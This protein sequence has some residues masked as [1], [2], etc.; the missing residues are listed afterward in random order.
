VCSII[1][2]INKESRLKRADRPDRW[3]VV[4]TLQPV[5]VVVDPINT[6]SNRQKQWN[7]EPTDFSIGPAYIIYY[8]YT[9]HAS[10][11]FED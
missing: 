2:L 6:S 3:V 8:L 10:C 7:D 9:F 11:I 1:L 4:F 5:V